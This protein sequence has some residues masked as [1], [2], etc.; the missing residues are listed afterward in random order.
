MT[1]SDPASC[2]DKTLDWMSYFNANRR[3][4]LARLVTPEL[5]AE[6]RN[7]P[8]GSVVRHSPALQEVLI[9]LRTRAVDGKPFA[10]AEQP[11]RKYRIG[12]MRG[13]GKAPEILN[14]EIFTTE[15][16]AIH[17]VFLHRLRWLGLAPEDEGSTGALP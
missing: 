15:R 9:Y 4:E 7:D 3:D 2:R 17:A 16:D 6:H 14:D 13:R 5:I 8:A 12:R 10:Y 1:L 11:Y